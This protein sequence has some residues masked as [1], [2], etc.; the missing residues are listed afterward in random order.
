[1]AQADLLRKITNLLSLSFNK[2]EGLSNDGYYTISTITHWKYYN[3]REWCT[4]KYK[5]TTTRGESS[6]GDQ[7]QVLKGVEVVGHRFDPQG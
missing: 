4:T 6:Y 3:I 5:L 2:Y 7:N 1:M